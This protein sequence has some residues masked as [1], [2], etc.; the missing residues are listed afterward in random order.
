VSRGLGR[1]VVV[2]ASLAGAR[3][4][5]TLRREGFEGGITL[6]GAEPHP[7]YQRP[8]LSKQYLEGTWGRERLELKP[9]PAASGGAEAELM[10]GTTAVGLDVRERRVR[11][12]G[13]GG[14]GEVSFDGL[15]I[16]T[17]CHL[18][19]LPGAAGLEGVFTLRT[20]DDCERLRA[21]LE[22]GPRVAVIGAGF[23][24]SEVAATC[25]KRGLDVTVIEALPV[26]L[27]G[28][29]GQ[30]MGGVLAAVHRD[31]GTDLRLGVGVEGFVG[32]GRVGGVRLADGSVVEA[33]LVVVG[34]GV[35]P[36]TGWLEGSGLA[37]DNGVLCDAAC[38]VKAEAGGAR[39][40][41]VVAAGD[42]ARWHNRLFEEDMRVEHWTNA[43]EQGEAAARNLLRGS[44]EAEDFSPPT[45][46]WSDQYDVKIQYVG[47]ARPGD[48]M[49]LA[50]G[51]IE[52]RRFVAAYLR[53]DR[54]V[55]ALAMNRPARIVAWQQ[56][57][58]ARAPWEPAAP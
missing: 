2:G 44:Q 26:P 25:R 30:E 43:V 47:R 37:L 32:D 55:A 18:R 42:V 14:D 21:I 27:A 4:A 16:A 12:S 19:T 29:L 56:R 17:G 51:S 10:L 33:D 36:T 15:V 31:H 7:P 50:E 13:S 1:I 49:E 57:V 24:G 8:P 28:A 39:L 5:D 9:S 48:R 22:L 45:Y 53:H 6:I 40:D 3:A 46:F 34:V 38:F 11:V 20:V 54:V 35:A 58:A 41:F 23:I 52:E